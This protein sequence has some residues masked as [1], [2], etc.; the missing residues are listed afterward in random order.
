MKGVLAQ[1]KEELDNLKKMIAELEA[2]YEL[3]KA[4]YSALQTIVSLLDKYPNLKKIVEVKKNA[5]EK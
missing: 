5:T 3:T 1:K 4:E 2:R